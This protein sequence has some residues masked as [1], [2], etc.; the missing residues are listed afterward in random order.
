MADDKIVN[1]RNAEYADG[2][3]SSRHFAKGKTGDAARGRPPSQTCKAAG[4]EAETT[5]ASP[6]CRARH[7][8]GRHAV[9]PWSP[10]INMAVFK[11]TD[12]QDGGASSS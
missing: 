7:A 9:N 5:T 2:T 10:G 3:E 11:N 6:R 4:H 12:N 8:D 1:P